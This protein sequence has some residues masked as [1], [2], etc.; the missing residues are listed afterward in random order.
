VKN[1]R[2]D[3]Y[4]SKRLKQAKIHMGHNEKEKFYDEL[5][6]AIW[7]Y[8]SDKLNIPLSDLSRDAAR[9]V[10]EQRQV[11]QE[12]VSL[13]NQLVDNCEFARYAPESAG[14]S[15]Q[16]DY[17]KAIDLISKLQHKLR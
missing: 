11:D 9:E 2:A 10:F 7:G 8:L 3:K 6:K 17:H 1:R 15:L 12:T 14:I 13:F 16:D 4:A 5:L